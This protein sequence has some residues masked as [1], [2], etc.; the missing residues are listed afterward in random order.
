MHTYERLTHPH[1]INSPPPPSASLPKKTRTNSAGHVAGRQE[2][3]ALGIQKGFEI[4]HELGYISGSVA[5]WR[6]LHPPL[7]IPPRA[8]KAITALEQLLKEFP[9]HNPRDERMQALLDT[10]RGRYKTIHAML[11]TTPPSQ[12]QQQHVTSSTLDF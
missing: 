3:K 12:Q 4:G 9:Y 1:L 2:G 6:R 5:V 10:I 7:L 11:H 8:E